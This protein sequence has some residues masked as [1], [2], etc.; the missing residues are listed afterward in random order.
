MSPR[1]DP[2]RFTL[3]SGNG[4]CLSCGPDPAVGEPCSLLLRRQAEPALFQSFR[5][6][7]LSA[8]EG[9]IGALA[10]Y[11]DENS[12]YLFGLRKEKAGCSLVLS[13]Q[14][15]NRRTVRVLASMDTAD[16]VLSVLGD[17]L[18]RHFFLH[19]EPVADLRTEYLCDEGL[20]S[21]KRFT[22]AMYGL[23]AV[24]CGKVCFHETETK[25]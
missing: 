21:P 5:V 14:I 19:G 11:Y 3:L 6:E 13:E 23:A 24:G 8:S 25:R 18:N 20:P 1:N 2:S 10:G 9:D 22:G 4:I 17:G 12:F 16:A 15:G 7:L